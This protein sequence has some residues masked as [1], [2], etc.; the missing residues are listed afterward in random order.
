[1]Q[2]EAAL[3]ER[4]EEVTRTLVN[5]GLPFGAKATTPQS[6]D[7]YPFH[8]DVENCKKFWDVRKVRGC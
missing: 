5:A 3:Q 8:H 1:M 2:D 4:I 6:I 7:F